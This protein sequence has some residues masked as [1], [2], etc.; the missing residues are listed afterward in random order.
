MT[1]SRLKEPPVLK[2]A[3]RIDTSLHRSQPLAVLFSQTDKTKNQC[4]MVEH[5]V[6]Q[7]LSSQAQK[8]Q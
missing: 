2:I 8:Q 5:S 3:R 6:S 7:V 1:L 4:E